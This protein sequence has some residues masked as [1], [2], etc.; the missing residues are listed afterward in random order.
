M[1]H[2]KEPSE[3]KRLHVGAEQGVNCE[4]MQALVTNIFQRHWEWQEDRRVHLQPGRYRYNTASMAFGGQHDH[5]CTLRSMMWADKYW[6]FSDNRDKLIC[7]VNDI[8]ED[9]LELDM[10]PKPESLWWTST[11]KHEDMTTLSVGSKDK[12]WDL[13]FCEVFDV[14]RYRFHRDGKGLQSAERSM[15]K[16]LRDGGVTST[17]TVLRQF[18]WRPSA[19]VSTAM[20]SARS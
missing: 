6:I 15:C 20:C 19:S 18:Q 3:W 17:F 14:L 7:M 11:H 2:E 4:H 9:L 13:Q 8:I 12:V 5:E 16:A 1:L 10:E